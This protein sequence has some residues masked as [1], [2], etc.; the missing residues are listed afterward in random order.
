[1]RHYNL[2]QLKLRQHTNHRREIERERERERQRE[3]ERETERERETDRERVIYLIF[4]TFTDA[5]P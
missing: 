5:S 4:I 2:Q 1:M 3:T